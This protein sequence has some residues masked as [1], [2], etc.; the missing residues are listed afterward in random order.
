[1]Y[2][3][4][5]YVCI[6]VDMN[7]RAMRSEA[8]KFSR[9]GWRLTRAGNLAEERQPPADFH[10]PFSP[11]PARDALHN[12]IITSS[13]RRKLLVRI[14]LEKICQRNILCLIGQAWFSCQTL[15]P[16]RGGIL[17]V[18]PSPPPSFFWNLF[19]CYVRSE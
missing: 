7:T 6:R 16:L 5:V 1:M 12:Q 2:L 3:D 19:A 17:R 4:H 11:N 15:P 9:S 18:I 13:W 10:S 14:D 8:D